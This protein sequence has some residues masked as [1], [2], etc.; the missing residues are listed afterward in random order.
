MR[1]SPKRKNMTHAKVKKSFDF[2]FPLGENDLLLIE[3]QCWACESGDKD[4][5][6]FEKFGFEI[7]NVFYQPNDKVILEVTGLYD[8][9]L[10]N[11]KDGAEQFENATIKHVAFVLNEKAP[12]YCE[13]D[14]TPE[15]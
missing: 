4:G 13:P 1:G 10:S 14:K 2:T 11:T 15:P 6:G 12:Y 5:Y 3:G 8:W 9:L 7:E